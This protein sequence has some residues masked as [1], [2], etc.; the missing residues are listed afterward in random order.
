MRDAGSGRRGEGEGERYWW[1]VRVG[2]GIGWVGRKPWR[3]EGAEKRKEEPNGRGTIGAF[4]S[5]R[6]A[7]YN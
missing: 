7:V 5:Q 4:R 6:L 1:W 2:G 3:K